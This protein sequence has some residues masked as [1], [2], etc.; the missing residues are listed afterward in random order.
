M[1]LMSAW[2]FVI[3]TLVAGVSIGLIAMAHFEDVSIGFVI[4]TL[5]ADVSMG[6][7]VMTHFE[8]VSMG[9]CCQASDVNT[10]SMLQDMW[11]IF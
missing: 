7:V 8:D 10:K 3:M 1:F 5:V 9:V 2:M 6:L 11:S 4:M